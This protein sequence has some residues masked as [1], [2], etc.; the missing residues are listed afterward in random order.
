[1]QIVRF[2]HHQFFLVLMRTFFFLLF[3]T[4]SC[5][6]HAGLSDYLVHYS[7]PG[8]LYYCVENEMDY[9]ENL[10][11]EHY[12][13]PYSQDFFRISNNKNNISVEVKV[14]WGRGR[15][16]NSI[17]FGTYNEI[18]DTINLSLFEPDEWSDGSG[19]DEKGFLIKSCK[20]SI[21]YIDNILKFQSKPELGCTL[22]SS[23]KMLLNGKMARINRPDLSKN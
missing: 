1:M 12:N 2:A 13:K 9:D 23:F 14:H 8:F 17:A 3:F 20:I 15:E 6:L 21:K 22:P 19:L 18:T 7:G 16:S 11:K 4:L 10:C 5:D